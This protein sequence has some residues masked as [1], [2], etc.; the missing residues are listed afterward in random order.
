ME[1][2]AKRLFERFGIEIDQKLRDEVVARARAI[3]LPHY[4]ACV[5]PELEAVRAKGGRV[6]DARVVY[7][8]SFEDQMLRFR[9]LTA[10]DGPR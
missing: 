4:F 2:A 1:N 7:P 9:S 8:K 10:F 3:N 6:V 5:M